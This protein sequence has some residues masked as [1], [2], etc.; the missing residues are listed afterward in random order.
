MQLIDRQH[1]LHTFI[2]SWLFC[3]LAIANIRERFCTV[4]FYDC[5]ITAIPDV[6]RSSVRFI[7]WF[8][9]RM[10]RARFYKKWLLLQR[11]LAAKGNNSETGTRA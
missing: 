3:Q 6:S 7:A 11:D 4:T 9:L 8:M 5:C 1:C 2:P 10:H